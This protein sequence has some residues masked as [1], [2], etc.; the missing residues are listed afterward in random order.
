MSLSPQTKFKFKA[1]TRITRAHISPQTG[2]WLWISCRSR[3]KSISVCSKQVRAALAIARLGRLL[4]PRSSRPTL[5]NNKSCTYLNLSIGSPLLRKALWTLRHNYLPR[6]TI[7]S[8][9]PRSLSSCWTNNEP[10]SPSTQVK[11][12]ESTI[13]T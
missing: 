9:Q 13:T 3:W 7:S 8:R 4:S 5:G 12:V 6:L 11:A 1:A 10:H 2:S